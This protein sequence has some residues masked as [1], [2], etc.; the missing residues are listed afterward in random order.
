M[1]F[2]HAK[3]TSDRILLVPL[4][5]CHYGSVDC[6][7]KKLKETIDWIKSKNNVRVI[8]MGDLIDSGLK[9][10][11][12]AGTFDNNMTPE[13]QIDDMITM[14]QPVSSKIWCSLS[15]NHE[16]R[17]RE[18]TSID[19]SKII[20]STLG[21]EYAGDMAFI[22][23]KINSKNYTIFATHGNTGALSIAGKLNAAMKYSTFVD[24][25]I[26]CTGHVHTLLNHTSEYFSI[27]L[28]DK[29]I[30]KKKRHFVITGHFLNYSGYAE[31]KGYAPGKTG[32]AKIELDG[33]KFDVHVSI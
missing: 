17:I 5:D 18:R 8:L 11:V 33:N 20:S 19:V 28:K 1:K 24:A 26:Y 22:K 12:G 14:L 7:V 21:I 2:I 10:S 23:A 3:E 9:D 31:Q 4:G 25:D 13:K 32:V 27:S 16:G 6:N 29:M 15:G 30:V